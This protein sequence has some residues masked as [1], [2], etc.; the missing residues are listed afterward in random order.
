VIKR[1]LPVLSLVFFSGCICATPLFSQKKLV[2]RIVAVVGDDIILE[3]ELL[4]HLFITAQQ[5]GISLQD[6]VKLIELK[7]QILD[8]LI[9]EKVILQ[10]AREKDVTVSADEVDAAINKDLETIRQRFSSE[11]DFLAA[12][13]EEGLTLTSY[14][15]GL[16][17]EREKQIL[18]EKFMRELKLPPKHVTDSEIRE[19]FEANSDKL[20]MR[21]A[22]V[23]LS[24]IMV[25][26]TLTEEDLK[27]KEETV[28]EILARLAE[29]P[30]GTSSRTWPGSTRM[31]L[32]RGTGG[33]MSASSREATCCRQSR[34]MFSC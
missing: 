12:L 27:K 13:S 24:H 31:I 4:E 15:D 25:A 5:A 23:T 33:V 20:G 19:Y 3:G 21:P 17:E 8:G 32:A 16:R 10:R 26:A 2:D 11:E 22:T 29:G 30:R 14:R 34:G 6:S 28:D 1:I 18:Q 7:N 9:T